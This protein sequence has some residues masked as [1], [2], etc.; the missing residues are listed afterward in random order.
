M[1]LVNY[2]IF[3]ID[4]ADNLLFLFIANKSTVTG[5]EMFVTFGWSPICY[6]IFAQ[7]SQTMSKFAS[8]DQQFD[9]KKPLVR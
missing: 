9:D 7:N 3:R 4:F 5:N 2:S 1:Y 8:S 6:D